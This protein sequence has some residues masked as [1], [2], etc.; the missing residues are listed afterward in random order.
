MICCGYIIT[1]ERT[2]DSICEK[3]G[4]LEKDLRKHITFFTKLQHDF[5]ETVCSNNHIAKV[6]EE[7]AIFQFYNSKEQAKSNAF[8]A[9]CIYLACTIHQAARSLIEIAKMC[10]V[11]V[12]D[13]SYFKTDEI[14]I[15][16]SDLTER[17]LEKL[18][19]SSFKFKVRVKHFSD[20]IFNDLLRCSPPQSALAVAVVALNND[21]TVTQN[22]I[23]KACDTSL[24]CL[25]RL[26]RIYKNDISNLLLIFDEQST[27]K[28][29]YC[30]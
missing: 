15:I 19:I 18:E 27:K 16:P 3:C 26:C 8:A 25:R 23:A 28:V 9:Y 30:S 12:S 13:I 29:F 6:I 5:I 11:N 14:D 24:S 2:G 4:K 20:I 7:E 21:K 17:A 10:F 22:A 1:D